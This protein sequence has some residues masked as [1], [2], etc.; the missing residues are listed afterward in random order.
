[1]I[2]ALGY[3]GALGGALWIA[4]AVA[5]DWLP[6]LLVS[7]AAFLGAL[8]ALWRR[9]ADDLGRYAVAALGAAAVGVAVML[10]GAAADVRNVFLTGGVVAVV[11][12]VALGFLGSRRLDG[13]PQWLFALAAACFAAL[14]A[15]FFTFGLGFAFL[16]AAAAL[17]ERDAIALREEAA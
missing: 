9:Y 3:A 14:P 12:L 2:R 11:A 6:L 7:L 8:W 1:M 16:G 10:A 15:L 13:A 5:D 17:P 4:W